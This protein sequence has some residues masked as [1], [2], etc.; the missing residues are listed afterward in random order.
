MEDFFPFSLAFAGY[1]PSIRWRIYEFFSQ[2][3]G[4][5]F[6][7]LTVSFA[8]KKLFSVKRSHLSI[9]YLTVWAIGVL[10]SKF[11][12]VPTHLGLFPTF[13]SIK[14]SILGCSLWSTWTWALVQGDTHG[15]I[16]LREDCQLDH[17]HLLKMLSLFHCIVLATLSKTNIHRYVGLLLGLQ[18][19]SIDLLP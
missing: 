10:F 13:S 4:C 2:Y 5:H 18:F 7:L 6:V 8:L 1:I 9:V 3:V 16:C 15:S 12:P 19:Y 14:I 11:S 17:R